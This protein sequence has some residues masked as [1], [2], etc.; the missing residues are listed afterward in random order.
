MKRYSRKIRGRSVRRRRFI[1]RTSRKT[2]FRRVQRRMMARR[3]VPPEIKMVDTTTARTQVGLGITTFAISA[4]TIAQGTDTNQRIGNQVTLRKLLIHLDL[5]GPAYTSSTNYYPDG[6]I[7]CILWT[8]RVDYNIASQYFA[9]V[10]YLSVINW[11]IATVYKDYY[12]AI[13]PAQ[14][15]TLNA[16]GV[17]NGYTADGAVPYSKHLTIPMM[18]PR[19]A[20]FGVSTITGNTNLDID[21]DVLYCTLISDNNGTMCPFYYEFLTRTFFIDA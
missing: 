8:P 20:N 4:T 12:I 11:Q 16:S 18:F 19:K 13:A 10:T 9:Q 14:T 15:A 3:P 17:V 5:W 21:K 1:R 6:H 2:R 7:R